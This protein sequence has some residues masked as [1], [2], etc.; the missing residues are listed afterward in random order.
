MGIGWKDWENVGGQFG[1][2]AGAPAAV[3]SE[4]G[5]IDCFARGTSTHLLHTWYKANTTDNW[6]EI[7]NLAIKDAPAAA[8]GLT[9][10]RGRVDVFVRGTDDL[11]KHRI[12]YAMLQPGQPAGDKTYTVVAGDNMTKI[13][14]RFG[15]SLQALKNLNPQVKWPFY[16]IHPGDKIVI[17]HHDAVP[18][19]GG[20]EPGGNWENISDSKIFSSPAALGWWVSNVLKRIDVFA[21]GD[22][23]FLIHTWWK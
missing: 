3:S 19:S 18:G 8:S 23:N 10:D 22:Q 21:Q 11:L 2:V 6:N 9:A 1:I 20:W 14:R 7:D 4:S 15:I 16:I 17:E 13:A 5:R 12:Y